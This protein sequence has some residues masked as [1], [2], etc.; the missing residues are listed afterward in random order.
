MITQSKPCSFARSKY[1]SI[2][3]RLSSLLPV[4]TST[5]AVHVRLPRTVWMSPSGRTLRPSPS[6]NGISIYVSN[7]P[8]MAPNGFA[9]AK[10]NSSTDDNTARRAE[11][12]RRSCSSV[13]RMP[14]TGINRADSHEEVSSPFVMCSPLVVAVESGFSSLALPLIEQIF[15]EYGSSVTLKRRIKRRARCSGGPRIVPNR[16]PSSLGAG[17]KSTG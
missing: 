15:L 11:V 6:S 2:C 7:W 4:F 16:Y 3:S 10:P 17:R 13:L 5:R 12:A 14:E 1:A 9:N 8:F